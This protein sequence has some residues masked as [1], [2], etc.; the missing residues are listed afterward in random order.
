VKILRLLDLRKQQEK[1][2]RG[3]F[4]QALRCWQLE[5]HRLDNLRGELVQ[6]K[7]LLHK[8]ERLQI[9]IWQRYTKYIAKLEE[10]IKIQ[11]EQVEEKREDMEKARLDWEESRMEKEKMEVLLKKRREV[12]EERQRMLGQRELDEIGRAMVLRGNR[13]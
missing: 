2:A 8:Q 4:S 13:V 1:Q 3:I 12:Q 10:M 11:R 6:V 9:N 7:D 5:A